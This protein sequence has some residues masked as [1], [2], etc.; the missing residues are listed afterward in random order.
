MFHVHA[1]GLSTGVTDVAARH[2]SAVSVSFVCEP[3]RLEAQAVLLAASLRQAHPDLPLVA[4]VPRSLPLP[5]AMALDALG[6]SQVQISNPLAD[7]YPIGHKIAA[8]GAGDSS[9]VRVFLDSDMLCLRPLHWP[10]LC[11]HPL[12]AKPADLA[13]FGSDALWQRLYDRF[14]L[15]Q[16]KGR[17]VATVSQQLMHPYFNAGMVA[18][19][20]ASRLAPAW[21]DMCRAI[22]AMEDVNPRRPWLDQIGLPLVASQL[23]LATRSLGEDW[24]YPAHMKPLLGDPCLVHYHQ[25]VVVAREP[26]LVSLVAGVLAKAPLVAAVLR[27]DPSWSPVLHAIERSGSGAQPQPRP[28]RRRWFAA[29]SR[30]PAVTALPPPA[31]PPHHDLIV[32]GIPRS[33]TSHV[34]KTLDSFDNVAV[35]NEPALLFEGLR[36]AA[37]PWTVPLLHA[38]LRARI[39][40]GEHVP[41]KLDC[42]GELTEDTAVQETLAGYSPRLRDGQ[43]LLATKNTLAYMARLE[44]ILRLMPHARVVACVRHPLDTLASW[45]GT[46]S[47]LAEGDPSALPVG[48]LADPFLPAHLRD[49]L[50]GIVR[51]TDP[52]MRRAAWWRLLAAE[53]LRWGD[54]IEIVRYEDLIADPAAGMRQLLGPLTGVAGTPAEPLRPSLVRTARRQCL[55]EADW[56]AVAMLCGSVAEAFGYDCSRPDGVDAAVTQPTQ[57]RTTP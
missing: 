37:D 25:P 43:W 49:G 31:R 47:H 10:T 9:G 19:T 5:T 28:V 17:V 4:A 54:R 35:I 29:G 40:A 16:P 22:D 32:T 13:T 18:T 8:L 27:N 39:D 44:G 34:C 50:Q 55:D 2:L 42:R 41:N 51:L 30:R 24:N 7:D 38:D 11:T 46:F 57:Q 36:Y 12:A 53:I 21:A 26:A 56:R 6:A 3:G 48:G 23:D 20:V 33:G 52:A 14:G 45:K 15:T 1:S